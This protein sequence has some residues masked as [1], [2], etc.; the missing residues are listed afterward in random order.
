MI[1]ITRLLLLLGLTI[2]WSSWG[3]EGH[4]IISY[5]MSDYLPDEMEEFFAWK[6]YLADH[7]ADPD[8][9]RDDDP[10]EAPKHYLDIDNYPEFLE[11]G[12]I[13]HNLDYLINTHGEAFVEKNGYLPWAT[14][15]SYD[16]LVSAM[17]RKDWEKAK[18]F[19]SDL[20]HYVADGFMPMHITRN[21]N[22][23]FSGNYGIHG[24]YESDMIGIFKN[25]ISMVQGEAKLIED[26]W[27]YVFSYLY[28][29]Y[30][31]VDS[32]L[33][34]DDFAKSVNPDYESYDYLEALWYKTGDFTEKLFNNASV[35]FSSLFYSAWIEAGKPLIS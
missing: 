19:A 11:S 32:I 16:S 12:T 21:Y 29:N 31:Y 3:R 4:Y 28:D 2:L 33:I 15:A 20:G 6:I 9:R 17:E 27:D 8:F 23:Q 26:P 22:G 14:L 5:K 13:S 24:R 10:S 1:K 30:R 18:L 7:S 34:A 35:A 25:K